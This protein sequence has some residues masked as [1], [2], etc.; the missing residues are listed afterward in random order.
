M[1]IKLKAFLIILIFKKIICN[2]YLSN[3]INYCEC[4]ITSTYYYLIYVPNSFKIIACYYHVL[5]SVRLYA[6]SFI[7]VTRV[8]L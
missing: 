3:L 1:F 8:R 2:I 6:F 5:H 7:C 4:T